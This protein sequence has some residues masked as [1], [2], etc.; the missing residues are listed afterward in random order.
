MDEIGGIVLYNIE[1]DGNLNGVYTNNHPITV[2][3]IFTE[4]ARLRPGIALDAPFR[5]YDSFYF[6]NEGGH[7][8][9]LI[10]TITN[11][12]YAAEWRLDNGIVFSGEGY[13]MNDRQIAISYWLAN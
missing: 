1:R 3:R 6:D 13:Q 4:I 2:A 7:T 10:F 8:C 12:I 5:I 11:G 9:T